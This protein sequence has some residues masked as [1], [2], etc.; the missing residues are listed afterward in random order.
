MRENI[1]AQVAYLLCPATPPF[2][3]LASAPCLVPKLIFNMGPPITYMIT[4]TGAQ[5]M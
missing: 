4:K 1:C 3:R 5:H 2:S